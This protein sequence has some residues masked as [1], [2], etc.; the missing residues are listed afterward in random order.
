MAHTGY[1]TREPFTAPDISAAD[2]LIRS[3]LL[4]AVFLALWLSFHALPT[5]DQPI[6]DAG[7]A[8]NQI[9]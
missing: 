4:A 5:L 2:M 1:L 6:N 7:D 9:G 8:A 3:V